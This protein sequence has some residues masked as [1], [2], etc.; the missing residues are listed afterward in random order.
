MGVKCT[1]FT[2]RTPAQQVSQTETF[3][4]K[5]HPNAYVQCDIDV[6]TIYKHDQRH[7]M[8]NLQIE[9][10]LPPP[11]AGSC[12]P[13]VPNGSYFVE[14]LRCS[15]FPK[16]NKTISSCKNQTGI[17]QFLSQ[18]L[19]F[20]VTMPYYCTAHKIESTASKDGK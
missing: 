19:D 5:K 3:I 20:W 12:K 11:R 6:M 15:C 9:C 8:K 4:K 18:R 2:V 16:L 10:L 14:C 13:Q 7:K 1:T 17:S